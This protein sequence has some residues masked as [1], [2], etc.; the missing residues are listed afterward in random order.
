ML[1]RQTLAETLASEFDIPYVGAEAFPTHLSSPDLPGQIAEFKCRY[2]LYGLNRKAE[3]ETVSEE[4][5][6]ASW[7][8]FQSTQA[9][10]REYNRTF[11]PGATLTRAREIIRELL[12]EFHFVKDDV[13]ALCT[14]GPGT[15]HGAVKN[16]LGHSTHY[17][18]GGHQTVSDRAKSLAAKVI[19]KYFPNWKTH[20]ESKSFITMN[21]NRPSHVPKDV[22]KCRPIS[23][24]P[25][26]NVF[27]Q[28]GV[29]RWLGRHMKMCGFADIHDGQAVNRRKAGSL[30][31]GTIDLSNA[32]DTISTEL[33]K[34][35]LPWDW[36]AVMDEI[37][38][39]NYAYRGNTGSYS[40]FSTQGN[41]FTF[42]LETLIF[43][44]VVMAATGLGRGEVTVYGDDII[45]PLSS[46]EK[47]VE[48]LTIA[49][50]TVNTEKSY[51]GQH[52]DIRKF[53]RESCGADYFHGVLVTP[54]YY[55]KEA[56]NDSDLA[57]LYNRLYEVYPHLKYT[58]EY[59]LSKAKRPLIGPRFLVSDN[60]GLENDM[61]GFKIGLN[62]VVTTYSSYFWSEGPLKDIPYSGFIWQTR[63]RKINPKDWICER[64]AYLTF[65][66]VGVNSY[67]SSHRNI[68]IRARRKD[69]TP[70][71]ASNDGY[72]VMC[73]RLAY[74]DRP[75]GFSV[76]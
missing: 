29:G 38:S 37:R 23:I 72:E 25:S 47:A 16:S 41:A 49:G 32:S 14:F 68:A 30:Q 50:F 64:T 42:P 56:R 2:Q 1:N 54:V 63:S 31:N 45:V 5:R 19:I 27:L 51:Y 34:Y 65:L 67:P 43:K 35:L 13:W 62:S 4:Q 61:W 69:I 15:F 70:W 24:E 73:G 6:S 48:G 8:N 26:L 58:L 11:K 75:R 7:L 40:N 39:H 57:T 46:A 53:F 44:A 12:P 18:I 66:L 60:R 3:A 59:I 52:D 22:R 10:V 55:R 36:Y 21:E 33:V 71:L 28:Q 9:Q 76:F 20:L 74:V 17:K